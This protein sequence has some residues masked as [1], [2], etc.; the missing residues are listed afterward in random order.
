MEDA[1]Q[2]A[3][4]VFDV[5]STVRHVVRPRC[6][7]KSCRQFVRSI[8]QTICEPVGSSAFGSR[9]RFTGAGSSLLSEHPYAIEQQQ[10]S[11][12]WNQD[13]TGN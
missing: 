12:G 2:A 13:C 10:K 5:A 8:H 9:T 11:A 1:V 6:H 3:C 4:H 7:S